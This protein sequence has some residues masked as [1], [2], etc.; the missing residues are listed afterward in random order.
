[1]P[2]WPFIIVGIILLFLFFLLS[3]VKL[4][5]SYDDYDMTIYAK[6]LFIKKTL[7]P[8][9]E[10]KDRKRKKSKDKDD[11]KEKDE[12]ET[13]YQGI[14]KRLMSMK[15]DLEYLLSYFFGKLHFRFL[16]TNIIIACD[17]AATTALAYGAV[18]SNVAYI[19]E[20]I[21]H[22]SNIDVRKS[23]EIN[24][25]TNFI[26]RKSHIDFLVDMRIRT[27]NLLKMGIKVLKAF[28][29]YKKDKN[30]LTEGNDGTIETN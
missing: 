8:Q 14:V 11:K 23:S 15:D 12:K 22:F 4:V 24:I 5:I 25:S 1:M 7:V 21:N 6:Y 18:S 29:K 2:I 10:K 16:K 3:P 27:I 9:K 13:G 30:E 26:S 20:V 19:I 17:D 28:M